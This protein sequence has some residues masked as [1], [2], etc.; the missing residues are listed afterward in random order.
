[1]LQLLSAELSDRNSLCARRVISAVRMKQRGMGLECGWR[2]GL[3]DP[4]VD[5]WH[6]A[7]HMHGPGTRI[8]QDEVALAGP[9]A[10]NRAE[11]LWAQPQSET[12]RL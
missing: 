2:F 5:H 11:V 9:G 1:M 3:H 12:S 6:K 8:W 4:K 10:I 7:K